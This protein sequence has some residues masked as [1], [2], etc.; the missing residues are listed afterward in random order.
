[1]D[2]VENV[3][4]RV[5]IH[6]TTSYKNA[7]KWFSKIHMKDSKECNG[8]YLIEM[9]KQEIVYDK[10]LYV[11]TSILDLSKLC[12]MQFHYDV[13]HKNFE[14]NYSLLY[15]DTDS[16][17]YEFRTDDLYEWI[18]N[19][20]I[21]FDL[22]DSKRPE[23]K[24]D[25]N[26]KVLGKFKDEVHSLIIT[27]F[28]AL[29]PKVYSFKYYDNL[30]NLEGSNIKNKKTLKGVSKVTVKNEITH[31]DY[32]NVLNTDNKEIRTVCSIRSFNHQLFTYV[33]DKVALTSWY[34]KLNMIDNNTCVPYGY[35]NK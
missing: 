6:A 8:L 17:V 34:D 26:K 24:D 22:S 2:T 4:N 32:V 15:S 7:E 9:Y 29:N 31:N 27:E 19:N 16:F 12:M 23:L 30:E 21:H 25:T 35:I 18:K 14:N 3:K 11:G 10:P 5:N 13:I 33:Q 28:L 1:M 20:K